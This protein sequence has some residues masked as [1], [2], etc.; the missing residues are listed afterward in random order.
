MDASGLKLFQ[1]YTVRGVTLRNRVG[2]SPM[3]MYSAVDGLPS[4]WHLPHLGSRAVGGAGLV[5]AEA[6]AVEERGR[7]TPG[8]TGIWN[9]AQAGAWAPVAAFIRSQG[10]VAGIQLA[11][12]GRKASAALPWNGGAHLADSEGGWP[13]VA[14]SALAFGGALGKTP[15]ALDLDGIA[16]VRKAFVDAALR[17]RAAGFQWIELHAAHGYLLHEF[18]SP[19]SNHR[20]D[21]YGGSFDGRVRLALETAAA[22]RA[23]WP[24]DLPLAVRLS[25]TDWEPGGW[26]LEQSVEL[27][28]RLKGVGV[29]LI[30]CSSGGATPTAKIPA[31]PGYQV[32]FAE[33]I[34]AQAGVATA[35]VGLITEPAQA[36]E[37]LERGR[38]DLVFLARAMLRDP[39]WPVHAAKALGVPEACTL[40]RQYGRA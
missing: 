16:L 17:A 18:L 11:H 37:I 36:E 38:A 10:A 26:D 21:A 1:P 9:D 8:C 32:P 2:V 27:A 39:Y 35:A 19:L 15:Q 28:R 34:R 22:V 13:M 31:G 4:A 6:T 14:P 23:V 40:P 5:I 33:A 25:C 30:D 24:E 3:C 7:I 12:A 20:T 29:D